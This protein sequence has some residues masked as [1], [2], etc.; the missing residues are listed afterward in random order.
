VPVVNCILAPIQGSQHLPWGR[1]VKCGELAGP[2]N[3]DFLVESFHRPCSRPDRQVEA[4]PLPPI[5]Y[6]F[7]NYAEAFAKH[8][9][10]GLHLVSQETLLER[11]KTCS[12]CE[13]YSDLEGACSVCGCYVNLNLTNIAPN[14]AAWASEGCPLQPPKWLPTINSPV[15]K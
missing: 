2:F 7:K 15:D 12:T 11:F 5:L 9:K 6:R 14:K 10:H 4:T 3:N 13:N 8:L 1:C